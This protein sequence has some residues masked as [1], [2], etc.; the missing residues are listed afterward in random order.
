[1][2]GGR[3][4]SRAAAGR[5]AKPK[6]KAEW[7]PDASAA[8]GACQ[9]FRAGSAGGGRAVLGRLLP[10][11]RVERATWRA[12]I[13]HVKRTTVPPDPE[14]PNE[15]RGGTA[16]PM[17][18]MLCPLLLSVRP[19]MLL[20]FQLLRTA[21]SAASIAAATGHGRRADDGKP[22]PPRTCDTFVPTT[23]GA[24]VTEGGPRWEY[25]YPDFSNGTMVK[26]M[27]QTCASAAHRA[28]RVGP[29]ATRA[30]GTYD[31]TSAIIDSLFSPGDRITSFTAMPVT[32]LGEPVGYPPMYVHHIHVG[33]LT[34]FYDEH[35]FT[36]HGDFSVGHDYG[37]GARSTRG[38]TTNI[39][40]KHCF[41]VDC[42]LP[43]A[44]QAILQD[45]R[46]SAASPDLLLYIDVRFELHLNDTVLAPATLVWNEAPHGIFGYSRFAV[47]PEPSMS[48]WT[49]RWPVS[50]VLLP[51]ARLHSH[52]ARHHRLFLLD[53]APENLGFFGS[54]CKGAPVYLHDSV[55]PTSG[56]ETMLLSN[57]SATEQTLTRLPST[58]C[59]DNA[60]APSFIEIQNANW[61]RYRAFLCKPH[62]LREGRVSTFVQLYKA[63]AQADVRLYPMH[64]NTWFYMNIPGASTSS[65]IKTVSYRYATYQTTSLTEPLQDL[66]AGS[67]DAKVSAEAVANYVANNAAG[68]TQAVTA[69]AAS[70]SL[71]AGASEGRHVRVSSTAVLVVSG[72]AALGLG[73]LLRERAARVRMLL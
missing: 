60:T 59:H 56:H 44:V 47:L 27:V 21:T 58:I 20:F 65:D 53:E 68:L 2:A 55:P 67:C 11:A 40:D 19:L 70:A 38:Y 9:L 42:P 31:I 48:W 13:N 35:W 69:H 64:T 63:V 57:L 18:P 23:L 45:M 54:H 16:N 8:D 52:F 51:T 15:T 66:A 43:F 30:G 7:P 46:V 6:G 34:D 28:V 41:K 14:L 32:H 4:R 3:A 62:A 49:M 50:G 10:R 12:A 17:L 33:R 36:T 72:I 25:G 71:V 39:P 5:S 73:G 37:I 61:A 1:M 24:I 29:F 22:T 26:V